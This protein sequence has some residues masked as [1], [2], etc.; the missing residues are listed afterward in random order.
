[1]GT[2]DRL[3]LGELNVDNKNNRPYVVVQSA[4]FI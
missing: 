4:K 1:M 2:W 3:Q